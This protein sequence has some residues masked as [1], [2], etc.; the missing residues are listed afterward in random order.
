MLASIGGP[1]S[2]VVIQHGLIGGRSV[3]PKAV[4]SLQRCK[5]HDPVEGTG[6]WLIRCIGNLPTNMLVDGRQ[7]FFPLL[8]PLTVGVF[9]GM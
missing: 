7:V 3:R 8:S 4:L 2:L 6:K 5:G 9:V 1:L